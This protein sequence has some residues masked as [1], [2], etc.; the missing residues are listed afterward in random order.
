MNRACAKQLLDMKFDSWC[1]ISIY[2]FFFWDNILGTEFTL[3]D[4][5]LPFRKDGKRR[6]GTLYVINYI[7][8]I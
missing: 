6:F 2:I 4:Y 8:C 3:S 7:S 1:N 5:A